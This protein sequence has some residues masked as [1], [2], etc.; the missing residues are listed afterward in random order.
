MANETKTDGQDDLRENRLV[1]RR[2][3]ARLN[4]IN[5]DDFADAA[6]EIV[7]MLGRHP[8]TLRK[9]ARRGEH[10]QVVRPILPAK[11]ELDISVLSE[12]LI[13][14]EVDVG[15]VLEVFVVHFQQHFIEDHDR[16]HNLQ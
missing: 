12:A 13:K 3:R 5:G 7:E 4:E 14:N 16:D 1:S 15:N 10:V 8:K 2:G 11:I 9:A 6:E